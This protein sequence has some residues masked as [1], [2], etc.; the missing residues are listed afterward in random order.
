VVRA[1]DV[2]LVRR[3]RELWP[4]ER[5]ASAAGAGTELQ[6]IRPYV[7]GDDVRHLDAAATARTG[8]PHVRVHVAERAL[9]TWLVLDRSASMGFGTAD[10]AKADVAEGVATVLATLATRRGNR[11]GVLGFGAGPATGR[12]PVAGRPGLLGALAEARAPVGPEGEAAS[13]GSA[14]DRAGRLARGRGLVVVVSDWRGEHNWLAP[15][16]RLR[17]RHAL[18]AVEVR[19][20]RE[21]EL[22]D[23]GADLALVDPETGRHLRVDSRSRRLR[24]R[25]SAAAA[26]EREELAR[27]LRGAGAAHVVLSTRGD[28]LL[29]LARALGG[30]AR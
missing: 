17:A 4:G 26:A 15:L 25:F 24:E 9:S 22:P 3:V 18:L 19:D 23:L 6:R 16:K 30:R 5:Q 21:Q 1:L 28:W 2:E 7:P 20:P 11:L 29:P 14:L 27:E 13:L 8:E 10:R 12:R